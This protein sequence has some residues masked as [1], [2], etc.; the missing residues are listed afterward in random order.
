MAKRPA[1][2]SATET[3]TPAEGLRRTAAPTV[4]KSFRVKSA[5]EFADLIGCSRGT[6]SKWI[7]DGMPTEGGEP[8]PG[9]PHLIDVGVAV[10]WLQGRAAAEAKEDAGGG[11][12]DL[13]SDGGETYED[14]KFRKERALANAAESDASIK[15]IAEAERLG[16]VA[17]IST[18]LDTVRQEYA[19]LATKLSE[20]GRLVEIGFSKAKPERIGREIDAMIRQAMTDNLRCDVEAAM[21][22]FDEPMVE[23]H[24]GR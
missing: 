9:K 14:A 15:A 2:R 16:S 6:V 11:P 19:S 17:P 3:A 10:R 23:P 8:A 22:V 13:P 24:V 1:S 21:E 5:S 18:M 20:V 4:G 12:A 7:R